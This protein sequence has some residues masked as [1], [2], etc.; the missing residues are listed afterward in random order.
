MKFGEHPKKEYRAIADFA[1]NNNGRRFH[2]G[3]P[4]WLKNVGSHYGSAVL[5]FLTC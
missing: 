1:R 4:L 5:P 2:N 3:R